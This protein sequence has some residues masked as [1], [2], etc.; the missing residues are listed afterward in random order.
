[1][2]EVL[3]SAQMF[4]VVV[5]V[6]GLTG[7]WPESTAMSSTGVDRSDENPGAQH[8]ESGLPARALLR[9][10]TDNLR[11]GVIPAEIVFSPD[12]KLVASPVACR[13]GLPE[14]FLFGVRGGRLIKRL[15]APDRP[16]G[17]VQC[18]A[19]SPDGS[20]LLWGESTG[21]VALWDLTGDKILFRAMLHRGEVEAV[22]LSADG[23]LMASGGADGTVHVR[24]VDSPKKDLRDLDVGE[25]RKAPGPVDPAGVRCL[26]FTP[27]GT[28]LIAGAG[29]S[30]S[31]FVWKS[32]TGNFCSGSRGRLSSPIRRITS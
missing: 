21:Y 7:L 5:L 12:G 22:V 13:G 16:P 20:K 23:K 18:L 11:T 26:A 2:S 6:S 32:R 24:Q 31:I 3:R 25:Q 10:G 28:R 1:M 27:D 15:R 30:G 4:A 8:D 14:V 17:F 29:L 9:I 19:F